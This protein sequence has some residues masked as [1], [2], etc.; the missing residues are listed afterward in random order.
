MAFLFLNRNLTYQSGIFLSE[1][2]PN[3][4]KGINALKLHLFITPNSFFCLHYL[5]VDVKGLWTMD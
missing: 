3:F 5:K 2:A 4:F 1:S